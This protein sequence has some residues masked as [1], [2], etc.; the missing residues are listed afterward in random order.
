MILVNYL[1]LLNQLFPLICFPFNSKGGA[2][3]PKLFS[4]YTENLITE[5][6]KVNEGIKLK[7]IQID[8]ISYADD[9]LLKTN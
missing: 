9:V 6:E 5:A 1:Y 3:S 7:N 2:S 8:V 4:I